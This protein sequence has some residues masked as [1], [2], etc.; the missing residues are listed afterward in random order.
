MFLS[1]LTLFAGLLILR[2]GLVILVD[3]LA[4]GGLWV[5]PE[6]ADVLAAQAAPA[7]GPAKVLHMTFGRHRW[8]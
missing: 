1:L 5:D 2:L 4:V 8:L 7:R 6:V 3:Y